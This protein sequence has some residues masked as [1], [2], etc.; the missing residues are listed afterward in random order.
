LLTPG[1][2]RATRSRPEVRHV[3][4]SNCLCRPGCERQCQ[5][6]GDYKDLGRSSELAVAGA[7]AG[8]LFD[9]NYFSAGFSPGF[10]V[11]GNM[12][13]FEGYAANGVDG[14]WVADGTVAGT[15][16]LRVSGSYANGLF[17]KVSA[18][19]ITVI[20]G[21][22]LF[23]GKDA[24]G[25]IDLWVTDGTSAG[26]SELTAAGASSSGLSPN[27]FVGL[28][29]SAGGPTSDFNADGKS[30]LLWQNSSGAVA[31]WEMNGTNAIA[32]TIIANPGPTWHA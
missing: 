29:T 28:P 5:S 17:A 30:D 2:R 22:A 11:L 32:T 14:L 24:S 10:T 16:E 7:N 13:L 12:A 26:T 31:V 4:F 20:G 1:H 23:A 27:D 21:T 3:H 9:L 6:W 25:K 8:G 19:D 18:P 15:R